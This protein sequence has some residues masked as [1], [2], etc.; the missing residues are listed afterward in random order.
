MTGRGKGAHA[1][2]DFRHDDL[3]GAT[4]YPRDALQAFHGFLIRADDLFNPLRQTADAFFKLVQTA[5]N[6]RHHK[7]VVERTRPACKAFRSSGSFALSRPFA[8]SERMAGSVVPFMRASSIARTDTPRMSVATEES[9]SPVSCRTLCRRLAS[10]LR[11]S[12]RLLR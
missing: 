7:N 2:S 12:I 6:L 10:R 5:Q 11:S 4:P 3:G 8:S 9:L 1:G